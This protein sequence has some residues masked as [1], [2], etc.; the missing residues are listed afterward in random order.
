VARG[1]QRQLD[2]RAARFDDSTSA[3]ASHV[4]TPRDAGGDRSRGVHLAQRAH[5]QAVVPDVLALLIVLPRQL[6]PRTG[7]EPVSLDRQ[8][9]RAPGRVTWQK[10][11]PRRESNPMQQA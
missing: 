6:A 8:S 2:V 11:C 5:A 10:R 9:S 7:V 4:A 3:A 1:T